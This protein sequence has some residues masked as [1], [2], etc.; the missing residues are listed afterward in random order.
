MSCLVACIARGFG[1][2]RF[3]RDLAIGFAIALAVFAFFVLVLNVNLPAGWL[4]PLF[5]LAGIE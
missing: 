2:P 1:S 3:L 4:A 5:R